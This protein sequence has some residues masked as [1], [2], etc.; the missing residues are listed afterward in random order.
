VAWFDDEADYY[1]AA[2]GPLRQGD[3]VL[4]P[5]ISIEP[6]GG[7]SAGV[8]PAELGAERLVVL[9]SAITSTLPEAPSIAARIR[10]DLAMVLPHDCALEKEFNERAAQLIAAGA[11]E[12]GAIAEASADS[13]LDR[14]IAV[15]PIR[16]YEDAHL[17]RRQGIRNGQRLGTF[18]VVASARYLIEP[19]WVDLDAPTTVARSLF[20]PAMRVAALS[21]QAVNYLRAALAKHW[22]HRDLSRAEE[23]SRTI[24][25]T[26]VAVHAAPMPKDRLRADLVLDDAATITLEGSRK[27]AAPARSTRRTV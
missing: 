8:A 21:S 1:E 23:L 2:A 16:G 12:D 6:G 19:G 27:P 5:T 20:A 13:R 14:H 26:I 7:E 3:L 22:A 9:W 4:A 24:G 10:W 18:P 25:R 17:E 15:A 11:S